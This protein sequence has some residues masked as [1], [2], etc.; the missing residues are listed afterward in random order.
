MQTVKI[1]KRVV[2][3][4]QPADPRYVAGEKSGRYIIFDSIVTG[5]GLRVYPLTGAKSWILKYWPATGGDKKRITIGKAADFTSDDARR[6]A[7]KY[8]GAEAWRQPA[9]DRRRRLAPTVAEVAAD[10]LAEHSRRS[11]RQTRP[12]RMPIW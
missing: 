6:I 2:T 12:R 9:A 5:F 11:G 8:R 4:A 3:D 7:D 1:T 10:F